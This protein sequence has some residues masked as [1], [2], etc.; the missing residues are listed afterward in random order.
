MLNFEQ[1]KEVA[2]RKL[3][4]IQKSS[5]VKLALLESESTAFEYGW[6]FFYQ[7]EQ[8]VKT[9]D[10]N[11]LVGGNAP[12]IVDKHDGSVILAGTA[13]S[14]KHYI[15]VYCRFKKDWLG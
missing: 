10:T 1:A 11:N 2:L 13:K 3:G 12:I 5:N 7:S 14:I 8:Y 15:E 9:G 6:V 4:E